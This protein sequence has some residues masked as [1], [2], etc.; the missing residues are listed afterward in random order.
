M[1]REGEPCDKGT[2]T[3][4]GREECEEQQLGKISVRYLILPL[5][6]ACQP[7]QVRGISV[8]SSLAKEREGSQTPHLSFPDSSWG[9]FFFS[10]TASCL[11]I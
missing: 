7:E 6:I 11:S 1:D 10:D 2:Q 5:N 9:G 4:K 8:C 3:G